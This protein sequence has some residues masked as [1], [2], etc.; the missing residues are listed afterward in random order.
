MGGEKIGKEGERERERQGKR[1]ERER[2]ILRNW[3]I[4]GSASLEFVGLSG[5]L[6][7]STGVNVTVLSWK[8]V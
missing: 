8:A 5:R 2:F 6:E 7:I 4:W 1:E 3:L